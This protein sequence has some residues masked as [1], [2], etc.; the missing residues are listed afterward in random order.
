VEQ[1]LL[2]AA[3]EHR[4][5]GTTITTLLDIGTGTGRILELFAD[6]IERGLGIDL[7][8]AMLN[9]A[10]TNLTDKGLDN[11]SVRQGNVYALDVPDGSIDLA[12]L[13]HVLHFLDD[14]AAAVAAAAET[15]EPGGQLIIVDFAPHSLEALRADHAHRRLGF[16]EAEI[17]QWCKEA[18]LSDVTARHLTPPTEDDRSDLLTVT[19]WTAYRSAETADRPLLAVGEPA[20]EPQLP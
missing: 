18:G 5:N 15:L 4:K 8:S 1:A 17:S 6:R 11:C 14:P 16:A 13:H 19:L 10:R 7:S 3:G 9:L 2:A 12:I 20:A